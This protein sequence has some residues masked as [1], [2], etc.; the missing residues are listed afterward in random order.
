MVAELEG[1]VDRLQQ[2]LRE[3]QCAHARLQGEMQAMAGQFHKYVAEHGPKREG[4]NRL[5]W[6]MPRQA[7]KHK[8]RT[9]R[10]LS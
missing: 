6:T 3:E 10:P 8:V 2:A 1:K 9:M 4:R 7:A 5:A